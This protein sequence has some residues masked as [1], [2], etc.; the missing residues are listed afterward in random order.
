MRSYIQGMY[1]AGHRGH[2]GDLWACTILPPLPHT[3]AEHSGVLP[4]NP[5]HDHEVRM[6]Q[7]LATWPEE[8]RPA[9]SSQCVLLQSFKPVSDHV[10]PSLTLAPA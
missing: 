9:Y 7:A 5:G 8:C 10:N 4:Q 3:R 1:V 6:E 2:E